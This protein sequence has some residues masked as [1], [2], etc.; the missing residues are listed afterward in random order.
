M[1][2]IPIE[3]RKIPTTL[4]LTTDV[5]TMIDEMAERFEMSRSAAAEQAIKTCYNAWIADQ[6]PLPEIPDDL[7]DP[8]IPDDVDE[9][10]YN[11]YTGCY[12]EDL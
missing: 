12:E 4:A 11:P 8:E 6:K 1:K 5:L 9:I 3:K 10:G 7:D 2:R